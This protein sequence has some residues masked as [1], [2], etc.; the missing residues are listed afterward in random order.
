[1]NQILKRRVYKLGTPE[2]VM[3]IAERGGMDATETAVFERLHRGETD[4]AIMGELGLS[5][6]A[7]EEIE[8]SVSIKT[9][10]GILMCIEQCRL[11]D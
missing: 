2:Q 4:I 3:Y 10:V 6:N 9:A 1:M 11:M 5:D 8:A 7:Y